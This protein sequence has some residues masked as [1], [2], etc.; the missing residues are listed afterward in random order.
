MLLQEFGW[1]DS[2]PILD[3]AHHRK[4]RAMCQWKAVSHC[5]TL[6]DRKQNEKQG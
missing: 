3:H 2:G 4:N 1:D 6:I 5:G